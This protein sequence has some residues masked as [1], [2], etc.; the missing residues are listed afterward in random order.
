MPLKL[1]DLKCGCGHQEID[2]LL[3]DGEVVSCSKCGETMEIS[4]NKAPDY[5]M[6]IETFIE[7]QRGHLD[8]KINKSMK[9]EKAM[10]EAVDRRRQTLRPGVTRIEK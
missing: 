7:H 3:E 5:H 1:F 8:S 9:R 6:N 10:K 4:F 2:Y